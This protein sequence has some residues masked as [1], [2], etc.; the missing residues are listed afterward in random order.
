MENDIQKEPNESFENVIQPL[1]SFLNCILTLSE[2]YPTIYYDY[3]NYFT[4]IDSKV[5]KYL[6]NQQNFQT[7]QRYI[8]VLKRI[9]DK[10]I[11]EAIP[12]GYIDDSD[13][14]FPVNYEETIRMAIKETIN[15]VIALITGILD[16]HKILSVKTEY[17]NYDGKPQK[18]RSLEAGL[19]KAQLIERTIYFLEIFQGKAP[20]E[21]I[22]WIGTASSLKYFINKL[23]DTKLF[24][25]LTNKWIIAENTF[26]V[27][28]NPI[29][30]NLRTY[31]DHDVKS[32]TKILINDSISRL[33][34]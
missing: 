15:E 4:T 3:N 10:K 20:N 18:M 26:T 16:R 7:L 34:D 31:K 27:N 33:I 30:K 11:K 32:N 21:R 19:I 2:C 1:T 28:G 23:F 5:Q 13:V 9:T 25:N 29:P 12:D 14:L 17:F 6:N 24:N 22:N 8:T